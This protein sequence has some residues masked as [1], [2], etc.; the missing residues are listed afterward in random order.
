MSPMAD[1]S[2]FLDAAN[3]IVVLL[4]GLIGLI[5]SGI[6]A[7]FAIKNWVTVLK[8]KT[9]QEIWAMIMEAADAAMTEV[10]ASGLSGADKKSKVIEIISASTKAAGIDISAFASQLND[11]IDQTIAFVNKMN[12]K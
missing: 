2:L 10:E 8:T 3:N 11:Y 6:G 4:T 9:S 5:G 1:I 12:K 7:Y